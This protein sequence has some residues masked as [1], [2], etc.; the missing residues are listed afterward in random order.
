MMGSSNQE[1]VA[2]AALKHHVLHEHSA[3]LTYGGWFLVLL[4][5]NQT[6]FKSEASLPPI[7][8]INNDGSAKGCMTVQK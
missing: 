1:A 3:S 5:Q 2:S 7:D 8:R 4:K 6:E